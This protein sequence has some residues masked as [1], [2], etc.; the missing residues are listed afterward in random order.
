MELKITVSPGLIE[1]GLGVGDVGNIVLRDRQHLSENGLIIVVVTLEKFSNQIMILY[2]SFQSVSFFGIKIYTSIIIGRIIGFLFI[3]FQKVF[4]SMPKDP[5]PGYQVE[6]QILKGESTMSI[7]SKSLS[8]K[9]KTHSSTNR[10][11]QLQFL[12]LILF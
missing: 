2:L 11:I 8:L 10:K 12:P 5:E 6:V 4:G 3:F 1:N 9:V 7:A